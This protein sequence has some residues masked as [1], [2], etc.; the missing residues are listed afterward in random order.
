LGVILAIACNT[1]AFESF[2]YWIGSVFVPMITVQ[3]M[4]VFLPFHANRPRTRIIANLSLWVAG[5][6][7]YRIALHF[8][9][10]CG[11]TIPVVIV[12]ALL[13]L[14]TNYLEKRAS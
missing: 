2:L 11:S 12:T 1:S 13:C 7:L 5:F 6:I 14:A 3:I 10:P 4:D 8:N 9:L